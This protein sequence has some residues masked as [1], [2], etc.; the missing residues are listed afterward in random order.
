MVALMDK[1][2]RRPSMWRVRSELIASVE[3]TLDLPAAFA[4]P[5]KDT[6]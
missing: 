3:T 2:Q 5:A 4:T 6:A 1:S